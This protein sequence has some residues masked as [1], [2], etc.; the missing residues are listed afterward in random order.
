MVQAGEVK[1][2]VKGGPSIGGN[3][4]GV[5]ITEHH[6]PIHTGTGSIT[7]DS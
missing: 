2:G 3:N 6:G 1:G 4:Y 5:A 7:T